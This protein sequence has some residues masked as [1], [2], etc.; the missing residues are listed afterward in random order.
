MVLKNNDTAT[1]ARWIGEASTLTAKKAV[2]EKARRQAYIL[3][4]QLS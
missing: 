2:H 4:S 3:L 1:K